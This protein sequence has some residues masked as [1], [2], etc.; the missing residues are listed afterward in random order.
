MWGRGTATPGYPWLAEG[1]SSVRVDG[2]PWPE[3]H[4]ALWQLRSAAAE[5]LLELFKRK[6]TILAVGK[7]SCL[8]RRVAG[9][10]RLSVSLLSPQEGA[11]VVSGDA[12]EKAAAADPLSSCQIAHSLSAGMASG[13]GTWPLCL[14]TAGCCW[15]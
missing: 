14:G 12:W 10:G 5:M 3:G 9:S 8:A 13:S 1:T 4:V 15:G 2:V 7:Y 6:N 11:A